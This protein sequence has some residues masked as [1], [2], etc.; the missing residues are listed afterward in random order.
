MTPDCAHIDL[1]HVLTMSELLKYFVYAQNLDE[2]QQFS[3]V[4]NDNQVDSTEATEIVDLAIGL[5]AEYQLLRG[6]SRMEKF[7]K[8][9]RFC[10]VK[11]L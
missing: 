9:E 5:G 4:I 11:S 10:D 6:C 3:L 2:E 7:A 1:A 8:V